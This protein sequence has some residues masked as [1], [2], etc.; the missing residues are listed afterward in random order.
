MLDWPVNSPNLNPTE[1]FWAI[2][3]SKVADDHLTS[4]KDLKMAI[5]RI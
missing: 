5:K 3:K 4:A 1:N 2:L